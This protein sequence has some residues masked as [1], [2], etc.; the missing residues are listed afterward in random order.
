MSDNVRK[1]LAEAIREAE[2]FKSLFPPECYTRWEFAGSIRRKKATVGDVEHLI[3][4]ATKISHNPSTL[5]GPPE[6]WIDNALWTALD[7]LLSA[8]DVSKKIYPVKFAN[9]TT[10]ERL[11]WGDKARGILFKGFTHEIY[12]AMDVGWG[13]QMV[14]RTGP[15]DF[16]KMM[17]TEI[18]TRGMRN[19]DGVVIDHVGTIVPVPEETDYFRVCGVKWVEPENRK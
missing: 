2:E 19:R 18:Q 1:P 3:I 8:G 12:T 15:G 6:E 7:N 5:F 9:G 4:P 11:K 17:V 16:S 10:G 13:A 14:I